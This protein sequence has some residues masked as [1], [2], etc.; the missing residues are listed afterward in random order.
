VVDD[1]GDDNLQEWLAGRGPALFRNKPEGVRE[2]LRAVA[3]W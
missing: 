1:V 3:A 2:P